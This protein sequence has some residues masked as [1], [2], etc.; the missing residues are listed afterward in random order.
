MD[1]TQKQID[2]QNAQIE[3]AEAVY[4][5]AKAN[6]DDDDLDSLIAVLEKGSK[7]I[8]QVKKKYESS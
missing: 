3:L 1:D 7:L 5:D 8:A 4:K 2:A 6:A